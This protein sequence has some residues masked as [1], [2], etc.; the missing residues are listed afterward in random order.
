MSECAPGRRRIL[1]KFVCSVLA[2]SNGLAGVWTILLA[3]ECD[4][5]L[6]SGDHE[7]LFTL[8]TVMRNEGLGDDCGCYLNHCQTTNG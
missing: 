5:Q 7:R 2:Q 4:E 8:P 6:N 1:A 3:Q